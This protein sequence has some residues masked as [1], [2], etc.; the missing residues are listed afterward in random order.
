MLFFQIVTRLVF[1]NL[2]KKKLQNPSDHYKIRFCHSA[3]SFLIWKK[4][5]LFSRSLQNTLYIFNNASSIVCCAMLLCMRIS[6][7]SY[8]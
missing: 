3:F 2:E 1:S 7:E 5:S 6:C 8:F 4:M